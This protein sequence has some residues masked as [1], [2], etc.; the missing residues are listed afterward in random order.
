MAII[1]NSIF[2]TINRSGFKTSD[3]V[4]G[5]GVRPIGKAQSRRRQEQWP[6]GRIVKAGL[7]KAIIAINEHSNQEARLRH[8]VFRPEWRAGGEAPLLQTRACPAKLLDLHSFS[9]AG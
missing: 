1:V 7:Q 3:Q 9:D 2:S 8:V 6:L 4:Q 5:Q